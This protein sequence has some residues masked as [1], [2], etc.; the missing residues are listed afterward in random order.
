MWTGPTCGANDTQANAIAHMPAVVAR[1]AGTATLLE[2]VAAVIR[3]TQDTEDAVAFGLAA[4]RILEH[5]IL[6]GGDDRSDDAGD[7]AATA[8]GALRAQRAVRTVISEL[9]DPKRS[10]PT[11][12][13]AELAAR[14]EAYLAP[15]SLARSNFD[16]GA[17]RG[18]E[19]RTPALCVI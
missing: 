4:A 15:D 18:S 3:V 11:R 6:H 14:M 1:F 16:V 13:D 9:R 8:T 19:P 10:Q 2:R 5:V 17:P 7:R 12:R